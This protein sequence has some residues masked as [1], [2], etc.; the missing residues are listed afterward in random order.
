MLLLLDTDTL[1]ELEGKGLFETA[2]VGVGPTE[3]EGEIAGVF[4]FDAAADPLTEMN[5][6]LDAAALSDDIGVVLCVGATDGEFDITLVDDC[7]FRALTDMLGDCDGT[8]EG[9]TETDRLDESEIIAL[10]DG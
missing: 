7:V 9:D 2:A 4:V 6:L 3:T 8:D 10:G 5:A 1:L